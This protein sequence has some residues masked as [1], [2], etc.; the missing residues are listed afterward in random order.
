MTGSEAAARQLLKEVS[1]EYQ[2]ILGENLVGIYAHG[3]L[4]FGCFRWA[5]S[6]IDFLVVVQEK[7]TQTEKEMLIGALLKRRGEAPEKGFEMS[8]VLQKH[9]KPFVHPTP[10]ELHFSNSHLSAAMNNLT[11]YCAGMNGRDCDL[12][13]HCTVI[14]AVGQTVVGLEIGEVFGEIPMADYLSSILYDVES[15]EED[16]LE[17]P[18]Y[19]TLNLCRVLAAVREGLILSKREGGQW[20]L[21]APDLR[22][23]A[24]IEGA[25]AAYEGG[26]AF[27]PEAEQAREF[28]RHMLQSIIKGIKPTEF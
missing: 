28:A 13:A 18:V 16:I 9:L 7:L 4:A 14:R 24:M 20:G 26:E 21:A 22:W 17:N 3:S 23:R 6:D 10:Y 1:D 11:A 2:E 15:A 19:V 25:L 5:V 12:A 8:V 27:E